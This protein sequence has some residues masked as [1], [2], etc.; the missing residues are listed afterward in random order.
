[1]ELDDG[2]PSAK[3]ID[4]SPRDID[5]AVQQAAGEVG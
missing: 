4:V 2:A 5:E 3:Q 1:L